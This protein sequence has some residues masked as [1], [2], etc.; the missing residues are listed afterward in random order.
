MKL[1]SSN[2]IIVSS[3]EDQREVLITKGDHFDGRPDWR[4]FDLMF[5]GTRRNALAFCDFD[6]LQVVRR[7]ILKAHTFPFTGGNAWAKLDKD[8]YDEMRYLMEAV[9]KK[10]GHGEA[11]V[12]MKGLLAKACSNI[13]NKYFC[14]VDRKDYADAEHNKY[15]D[16]FDKLF[17]EVNTGRACDF[18]P[19][20]LELPW[21]HKKDVRTWTEDV[22]EYVIKNLLNGKIEDKSLVDSL[23]KRVQA[24]E[25][26]KDPDSKMTNDAALFALED[27]LGGHCAVANFAIRAM[28]DLAT[29][30]HV[31]SQVREELDTVL[32]GKEFG[33]EDKKSLPYLQATFYETVRTTCSAIV[34]HV[35]NRNTTIAGYN[36]A[37]NTVIFIN[38]HYMNFNKN[39]WDQP[40]EYNPTRFIKDNTFQKP[41]HFQPFSFGKRQCVGYKIV[42]YVTTYIL[43]SIL[44]KY[45]VKCHEEMRKQPY[46][47]LG[48]APVPFYFTLKRLDA[49]EDNISRSLG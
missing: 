42:E 39:Y 7:K 14:S 30:P 1:G 3:E 5:G 44:D 13:F 10:C 21:Q 19:W 6:K 38:N 41:K 40:E 17:W 35:A 11:I 43:A 29:R 20:L 37:A 23:M 12:D 36:V 33:L 46:G 48:L 27:V 28:I 31:Q 25:N 24:D 47:Q 32:A 4:R 8:C 26:N 9:D 2:C 18:L 22:R 34:P 45:Q 49:E 16:V 15:C